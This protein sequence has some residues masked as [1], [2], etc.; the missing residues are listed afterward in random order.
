MWVYIHI[1]KNIVQKSYK[2]R[3]IHAYKKV[4]H[5]NHMKREGYIHIYKKT[6]Y[7]K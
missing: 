3:A 7:K 6:S 2:K 5:E 4:S 1:Y